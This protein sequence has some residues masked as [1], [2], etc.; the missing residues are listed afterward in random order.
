MLHPQGGTG[1]D[2]PGFVQGKANCSIES[3]SDEAKKSPAPA[4]TSSS[5]TAAATTTTEEET[6]DEKEI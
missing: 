5:T 2:L 4:A 1:F 6:F 3:T